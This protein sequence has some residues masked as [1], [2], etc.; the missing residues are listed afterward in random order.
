MQKISSS[1]GIEKEGESCEED[2]PVGG[3]AEGKLEGKAK[4]EGEE[5]VED[6]PKSKAGGGGFSWFRKKASNSVYI[7]GRRRWW[8]LEGHDEKE[9]TSQVERCSREREGR[10]EGRR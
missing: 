3:D 8:T 6:D 2:D 7:E 10:E 9:G 4:R 1:V 5:G